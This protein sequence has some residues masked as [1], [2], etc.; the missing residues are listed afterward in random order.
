MV[1]VAVEERVL[2]LQKRKR[3]LV[4]HALGKT[5]KYSESDCDA[6]ADEKVI[7]CCRRGSAR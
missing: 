3:A 5:R 2:D 7:I 6:A 1:Y 4:H